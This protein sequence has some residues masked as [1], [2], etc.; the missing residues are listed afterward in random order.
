MVS[1]VL[2]LAGKIRKTDL[3][4]IVFLHQP[5]VPVS[6]HTPHAHK[7]S[8]KYEQEEEQHWSEGE[9]LH[10]ASAHSAE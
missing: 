1:R 7:H 2:G 5:D 4:N 3:D 6:P 10:A 8:R 9:L